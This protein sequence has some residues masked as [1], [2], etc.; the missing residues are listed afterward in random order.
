MSKLINTL[1]AVGDY[2]NTT[3]PGQPTEL[4]P[5]VNLIINIVIGIIGLV[6]VAMVIYGGL[7][8]TTS[9]GDSGKVTS[10]K[11]TILY[12]IIGLI[13]AV[14]A[15]AIVNFVITGLGWG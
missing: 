9:A 1:G 6:A 5:V 15:F 4:M 11:N 10:A 8:Y 12:G 2:V 3:N 13:V 7:R 14:L